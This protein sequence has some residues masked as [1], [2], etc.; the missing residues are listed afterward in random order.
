[1]ALAAPAQPRIALVVLHCALLG[2]CRGWGLAR[3]LT[4]RW[5]WAAQHQLAE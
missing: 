1:M 4:V 3:G 5:A 2:S